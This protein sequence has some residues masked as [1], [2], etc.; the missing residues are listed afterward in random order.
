MT[1]DDWLHERV[2]ATR[3]RFPPTRVPFHMA[4]ISLR[5][6]CDGREFDHRHRFATL[7]EAIVGA[8]HLSRAIHGSV[9]IC[10][11]DVPIYGYSWYAGNRGG[12]R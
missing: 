4:P 9:A 7:R 5:V 1:W 11:R 2:G 3:D 6:H 12:I 10:S 8:I